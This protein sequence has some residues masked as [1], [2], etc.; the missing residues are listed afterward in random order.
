[1]MYR[2]WKGKWNFYIDVEDLF[3]SINKKD[4]T[5]N[6]IFRGDIIE[7]VI[8]DIHLPTRGEVVYD[9]YFSCYSSKNDAGNTPLWRIGQIKIVGNIKDEKESN[10]VKE[11]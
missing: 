4:M 3:E 11:N 8:I 6:D 5:G 7:G 1:M 9:D 10:D 2:A